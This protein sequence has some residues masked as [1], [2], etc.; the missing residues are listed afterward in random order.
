MTIQLGQILKKLRKQQ[1][2]NQQEVANYLFVSR[3]T[4]IRYER[5]LV[6]TPLSKLFA[7]ASLYNFDMV[8]LVKLIDSCRPIDDLDNMIADIEPDIS[9]RRS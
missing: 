2:L 8:D 7:L 4:Y 3:P 1:N 6:E 9:F 5:N